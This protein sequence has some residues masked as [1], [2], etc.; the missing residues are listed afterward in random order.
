M[1][2]VRLIVS[3]SLWFLAVAPSLAQ[4]MNE[5]DSR[6]ANVVTTSDLVECLSKARVSTD[7]ELNSLYQQIRKKLDQDDANR[8]TVAQRLWV[9]YRDANCSAERSLYGLGTAAPPAYL[10]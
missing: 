6:C 2:Q 3:L 8:L 1:L 7:A 10:A 4:H 9:Q 5:K